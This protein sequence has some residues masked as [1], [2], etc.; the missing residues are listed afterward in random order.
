M[1]AGDSL[2]LGQGTALELQQGHEGAEC[3]QS[4]T[5]HPPLA[6]PASSPAGKADVELNQLSSAHQIKPG[7]RGLG[8]SELCGTCRA[9]PRTPGDS[10]GQFQAA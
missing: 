5:C 9:V 10:G 3:P 2:K 4:G 1:T 7:Q 6:A 8:R